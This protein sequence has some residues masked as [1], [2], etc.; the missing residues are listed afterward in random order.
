MELVFYITLPT[1]MMHGQTQ[2]KKSNT[3]EKTLLNTEFV[4]IYSTNLP[5]TLPILRRTEPD[6]IKTYICLYVKY[7]VFLSDFNEP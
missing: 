6:M 4:L 3:F 5:K 2:I 1:L 7:P